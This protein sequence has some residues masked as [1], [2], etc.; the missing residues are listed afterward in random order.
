MKVNREQ[1]LAA[2]LVIAATSTGCN[3]S[4]R[5][6]GSFNASQ[7]PD[8]VQTPTNGSQ[9]LANNDPGIGA[10]QV[11]GATPPPVAKN[12]KTATPIKASGPA[13]ENVAPSK[14]NV[15]P[16]SENVAPSKEAIAPANE[17]I[18]PSNEGWGRRRGPSNETAVAPARENI[19]PAKEGGWSPARENWRRPGP[20]SENVRPAP[21]KPVPKK[22]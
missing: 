15:A 19:A 6:K 9:P 7:D 21:V 5:M 1:F 3:L 14:E 10:R 16:A 4:E 20:A 11:K 12:A 2:A 18:A 17:N 22:A 8:A 13:S